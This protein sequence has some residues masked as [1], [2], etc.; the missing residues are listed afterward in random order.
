RLDQLGK[1]KRGRICKVDG[2]DGI[3]I[4]LMEMGLITGEVVEFVGNAPFGQ[5]STFLTRGFRLALRPEESRRI[6]V[7][8]VN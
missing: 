5:P 3:S 1:G 6:E 4:R 7:E 2:E 8:L